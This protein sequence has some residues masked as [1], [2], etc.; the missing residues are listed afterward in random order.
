[1]RTLEIPA[2][3]M[4]FTGDDLM[5]MQGGLVDAINALCQPYLIDGKGVIAGMQLS[6]VSG[7]IV[8]APGW[9]F[10]NNDLLQFLGA[11][12]AGEDLSA[13]ELYAAANYDPAGNDVFADSISRD[14]YFTTTAK[15]RAYTSPG[16]QKVRLSDLN[17]YRVNLRL[18]NYKYN[19]ASQSNTLLMISRFGNVVTLQGYIGDSNYGTFVLDV[20]SSDRPLEVAAQPIFYINDNSKRSLVFVNK[21]GNVVLTG[22]NPGD[23]LIAYINITW[24]I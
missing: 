5:W 18:I 10:I 22:D 11:T 16:A 6:I 12:I 14:T 4:P 1:M 9:I 13:H 24:Q 2:G 23:G 8:I 17:I 19:I 15:H 3:G 20:N 21:F 7:S